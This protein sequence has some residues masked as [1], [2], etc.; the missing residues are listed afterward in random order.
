MN[1][2]K[3][4]FKREFQDERIEKESNKM[5]AKLFWVFSVALMILLIVK[6]VMGEPLLNYLLEVIALISSWGYM[7]IQ[8]QRMGLWNV[9]EL[10]DELKAFQNSIFAKA[11][12]IMFFVLVFGNFIYMLIVMDYFEVLNTAVETE[13]LIWSQEMTWVVVYL[14]VVFIPS[15][16]VTIVSIGKG[17][18]SWGSKK[19]E[20]VGKKELAKG[21][22]IGALFYGVFMTLP[23]LFE[24]GTFHPEG[25]LMTFIMTIAWGIPFYFIMAAMR[26]A[27]EKRANEAMEEEEKDIEE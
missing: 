22:A 4:L 11:S 27:S 2:F 18:L 13:K 1:I 23:D 24:G 19:R 5:Y 8:K 14:A 6:I 20:K 16:V 3:K 21:T 12:M 17:W 26:K 25:L 7:V 9:K 15:V 10:D